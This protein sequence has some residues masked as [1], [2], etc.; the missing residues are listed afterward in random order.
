MKL[1]SLPAS[2]EL[3]AL[4]RPFLACAFLAVYSVSSTQAFRGF[5]S[6]GGAGRECAIALSALAADSGTTHSADF[7][8]PALRGETHPAFT[9]GDWKS[10][11]RRRCKPGLFLLQYPLWIGL[12]ADVFYSA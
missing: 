2:K 4:L 9:V 5:I 6:T 1:R 11:D 12:V 7:C 3:R 8:H 10:S